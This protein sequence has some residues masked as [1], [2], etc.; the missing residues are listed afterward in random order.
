MPSAKA[1]AQIKACALSCRSANEWMWVLT[2]Q[3]RLAWLLERKLGG[4]YAHLDLF[5]RR[6]PSCFGQCSLVQLRTTGTKIS[7]KKW[8]LG[9]YFGPTPADGAHAKHMQ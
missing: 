3:L 4:S 1:A 2:T 6:V 9:M 8:K 5:R 7:T